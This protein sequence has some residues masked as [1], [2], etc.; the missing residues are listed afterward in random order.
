ME[1]SKIINKSCYVAGIRIDSSTYDSATDQIKNLAKSEKGFFICIGNAHVVAEA[2]KNP[3]FKKI[4]NSA[5]LVTSDG[6]PLLWALK[7]FGAK[8]AKRVTGTT[9][10]F[11]LCKMAEKI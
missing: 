9:L 7:L 11:Y 3:D 4:I 2:G 10:T 1:Q 8:K 5:E 6:L